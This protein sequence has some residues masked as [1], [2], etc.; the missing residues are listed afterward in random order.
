MK[1]QFLLASPFAGSGK[2]TIA[3]GLLRVWQRR[4]I[5]VQPFKCGPDSI[6]T[7]YHALASGNDSVN[8]DSWLASSGHVQHLYNRYGERADI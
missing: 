5:K 3:L 6:D 2:T 8:L 7:Q 1:P 4:G